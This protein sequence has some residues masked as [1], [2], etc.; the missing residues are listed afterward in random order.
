MANELVYSFQLS[1]GPDGVESTKVGLALDRYRSYDNLYV[2]LVCAETDKEND[3]YAGELY[4]DLSV[5]IEPLPENCICVDTNNLSGAEKFIKKYRLG[6]FTGMYSYS[7]YSKYPIYEM[8]ID[9]L[10]QYEW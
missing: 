1:A 4:G 6:T 3:I 8:D 10:K 7:G 9:K 2:G 5:N